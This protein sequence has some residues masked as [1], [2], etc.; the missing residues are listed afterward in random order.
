MTR[1]NVPLRKAL[2]GGG[3][4]ERKLVNPGG[5]TGRNCPPHGKKV[6]GTHDALFRAVR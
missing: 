6:S 2:A 4:K 3:N 5:L 1:R